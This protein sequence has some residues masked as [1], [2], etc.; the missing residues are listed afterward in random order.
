MGVGLGDGLG[1]EPSL[2]RSFIVEFA[3]IFL[4][5]LQVLLHSQSFSVLFAI[6]ICEEGNIFKRKGV[7][8]QE[9][10]LSIGHY[11]AN[12]NTQVLGLGFG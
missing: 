2:Q 8:G 5:L 1:P 4:L 7:P 11:L 12:F 9:V 10:L 6:K 3:L